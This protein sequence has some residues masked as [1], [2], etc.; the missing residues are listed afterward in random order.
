M[1][2][3]DLWP[4]IHAAARNYRPAHLVKFGILPKHAIAVG[5]LGVAKISPVT[6]GLF[7]FGGELSAVILPV[8]WGAIPTEKALVPDWEL[9]DILAF[10]PKEPSQLWLR[11]GDAVFLGAGALDHLYLGATLKIHRTPMSWLLDHGEGC[12]V[13][14][15]PRAADRLRSIATVIAE[16]V[17]HAHDIRSHLQRPLLI[18]EIRVPEG[19]VE[20]AA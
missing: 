5:G 13:L 1:N 19:A 2:A 9:E 4:E 6:D 16:D 7:E 18:P 15:W 14:D 8:Y 11:C 3:S 12:V 10:I 17:D 20:R